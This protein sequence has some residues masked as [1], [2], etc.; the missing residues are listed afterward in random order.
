PQG[1]DRL[2]YR[3]ARHEIVAFTLEARMRLDVDQHQHV[4]RRS[5][6]ASGLAAPDN[7]HLLSVADAG[8]YLDFERARFAVFCGHADV[9][10]ESTRGLL[11][12]HVHPIPDVGALPRARR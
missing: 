12:R 1:G 2:A 6:V 9:R 11:E 10:I 8:R 3:G 7:A 5:A 4:A